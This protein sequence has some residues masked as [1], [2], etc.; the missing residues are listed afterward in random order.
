MNAQAKKCESGPLP[1]SDGRARPRQFPPDG[2]S[3]RRAT[4]PRKAAALCM[5]QVLGAHPGKLP[6]APASPGH[7]RR[8]RSLVVGAAVDVAGGGRGG[9]GP[10]KHRTGAR[11]R[12][13]DQACS[14][15][16]RRPRRR[17]VEFGEVDTVTTRSTG[18]YASD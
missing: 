2:A 5:G 9:G 11:C 17:G 14:D 18:C 8:R 10:R 6:A 3:G 7:H 16:D 4:P 1:E 15:P 12:P 13:S